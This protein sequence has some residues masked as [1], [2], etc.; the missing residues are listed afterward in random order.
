MSSTTYDMVSLTSAFANPAEAQSDRICQPRISK[1]ESAAPMFLTVEDTGLDNDSRESVIDRH[2]I[3]WVNLH[4][5]SAAIES[6]EELPQEV[7]DSRSEIQDHNTSAGK[8]R[9]S[10]SAAGDIVQNMFGKVMPLYEVK[11][12]KKTPGQQ[13][14]LEWLTVSARDHFRTVHSALLGRW[15]V[16]PEHKGTCVLCPEDWRFSD[17]LDL[18]DR[19]NNQRCPSHMLPRAWYSHSDHGTTM[20]R[21]IAWFSSWPHNGGKLDNFLGAGPYQFMHGSHLCHHDHCII[22]LTYERL[23]TNE[24]R[25]VCCQRARFLRRERRDVPECCTRHDPP[26]LMQV[27]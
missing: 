4:N 3:A 11:Q 24:D 12:S 22:H 15:G 6:A 16:G 21:A 20:A 1:G 18:M 25:K 5:A 7:V 9:Q 27:G 23:D 2:Q 14:A 19:F 10:S 26:C 13:R 17:P 8:R